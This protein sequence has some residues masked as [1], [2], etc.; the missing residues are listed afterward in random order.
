MEE[1][2]YFF[3]IDF[4]KNLFSNSI[5]HIHSNRFTQE[6]E[7]F[8]HLIDPQSRIYSQKRYTKEYQ[9]YI[10]SFTGYRISTTQSKGNIKLWCNE[11]SNTDVLKKIQLKE[12]LLKKLLQHKLLDIEIEF[13]KKQEKLEKDFLYKY[14]KSLS[15]AGHMSFPKDEKRLLSLLR[16]GETIIK[17]KKLD[18]IFDFSTLYEKN[19][20]LCRYE[21]EV[22]EYYQY[23]GTIIGH[24]LPELNL[25]KE[26]LQELEKVISEFTKHYSGVFSVDSFLYRDLGETKLYT[27]C[28][29]NARKTMGYCAYKIKE[30]YFSS[31]NF[32]K[33]K[34]V[35]NNDLVFDREK[36]S[37]LFDDKVY[38]ISPQDNR[39]F[40]FIFLG[41]TR[42]EL[43]QLED[44]FISDY[45]K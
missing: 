7:F 19:N 36:L 1:L 42:L 27:A 4:E 10:K 28:E 20:Y 12:N 15:G 30:K 2:T 37:R 21:N 9:D 41:A 6:F 29:I 34:L 22:D 40:V 43:S 38:L 11:Y 35:R 32:L 14:S 5:N 17:E 25:Y 39:F 3:N 24:E 31:S 45:F 26:E 23:K 33:M 8:I 16:A 18:R 44:R 13:I